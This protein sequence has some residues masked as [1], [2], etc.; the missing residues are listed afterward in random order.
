[1]EKIIGGEY[2][3]T[4]PSSSY[5]TYDTMSDQLGLKNYR[6]G[7]RPSKGD[8]VLVVSKNHHTDRASEI[9]YHVTR[10]DDDFLI[11]PGGIAGECLG[12]VMKIEMPD[13]P[14]IIDHTKPVGTISWDF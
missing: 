4:N 11:G 2:L 10:G 8:K 9:V 5:T 14:S 7:T 13:K 12:F 1:M 3:I 6:R